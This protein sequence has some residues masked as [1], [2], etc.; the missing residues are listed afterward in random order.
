METTLFY[1]KFHIAATFFALIVKNLGEDV[2][3]VALVDHEIGFESNKLR[4]ADIESG[5]VAMR[6]SLRSIKV[7]ATEF[8][9]RA[10][11]AER[12]HRGHGLCR[13]IGDL[14]R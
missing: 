12:T 11:G 14:Y 4:V 10:V 1:F 5:G 6:R 13:Q 7:A 2:F 3:Q 9:H 8:C